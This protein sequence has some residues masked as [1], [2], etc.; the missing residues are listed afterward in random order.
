MTD[1]VVH[2]EP[3]KSGLLLDYGRPTVPMHLVG[4]SGTEPV[5]KTTNTPATGNYSLLILIMLVITL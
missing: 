4:Y 2:I 1:D 3:V 5:Y